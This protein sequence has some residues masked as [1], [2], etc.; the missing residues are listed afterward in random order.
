[1]REL[2]EFR[3][4]YPSF[5]AASVAIAG[6][7]TDSIESHEKWAQRLRIPF[8]LLSDPERLAGHELGLLRKLG[9]GDWSVELF[10]RA[11]LLVDRTGI[12]AAAWTEVKIRGHAEQVLQAARALESTPG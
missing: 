6:V 7:S 8:P 1:V 3:E 4:A 9:L 2:R 10:R 12:V 11:T 5:E